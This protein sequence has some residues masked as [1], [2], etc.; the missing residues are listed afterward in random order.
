MSNR[1]YKMTSRGILTNLR[2]YSSSQDA[3]GQPLENELIMKIVEER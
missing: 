1:I 3:C 2:S